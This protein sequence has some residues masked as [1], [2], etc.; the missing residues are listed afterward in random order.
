MNAAKR[1]RLRQIPGLL[2]SLSAEAVEL[3]EEDGYHANASQWYREYLAAVAR[4]Q[5]VVEEQVEGGGELD[6]P[7]RARRCLTDRNRD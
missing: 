7:G 6:F 5:K 1:A 2:K 3:L 4:L